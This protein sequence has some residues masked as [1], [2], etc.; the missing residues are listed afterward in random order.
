MKKCDIW[1]S[2]LTWVIVIMFSNFF[3][4]FLCVCG[5][6]VVSALQYWT[7]SIYTFY[8]TLLHF[9]HNKYTNKI[10]YI[11]CIKMMRKNTIMSFHENM[12]GVEGEKKMRQNKFYFLL[13][14]LIRLRRKGK[15]FWK[16]QP[17]QS[18]F[19]DFSRLEYF[20]DKSYI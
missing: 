17:N 13:P 4:T 19:L 2:Y 14:N 5:E 10:A 9:A 11:M 3:S 16:I 15:I 18:S 20:V 7:F 1:F 12:R 8:G 6:S